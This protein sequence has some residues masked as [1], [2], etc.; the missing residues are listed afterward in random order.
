MIRRAIVVLAALS[1]LTLVPP[2]LHVPA[3]S[4]GPAADA[5]AALE[6]QVQ[7]NTADIAALKEEIAAWQARHATPTSSARA[8]A[9][10]DWCSDTH[11]DAKPTPSEPPRPRRPLHRLL[12]RP[13]EHA[14]ADAIAD[15]LERYVGPV[16]SSGDQRDVHGSGID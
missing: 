2:A 4:A 15:R 5:I 13:H 8:I 16:R 11:V 12:R 9:Y 6:A 3:A 10:P 1:L 14:D 7:Q